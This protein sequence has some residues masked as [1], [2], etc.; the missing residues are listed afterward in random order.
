[1]P[2]TGYT[3]FQFTAGEQPTVSKWNLIPNNDAAMNSGNGINDGAILWRH[4]ATDIIPTGIVLLYPG[5]SSPS[6]QWLVCDGSAVS[7]AT[8]SALFSLIGTKYGTGNG[9]TTF[10]LPN[11]KGRVPVGVNA[12]DT[13]FAALGQ[14][15][16]ESTHAL[17]TAELAVH[18]HTISD[19]GHSHG[20]NDPG[21]IHSSNTSGQTLF[22]AGSTNT[23]TDNRSGGFQ[24]I[25]WGNTVTGGSGT[26]I[27]LSGSGTGITIANA[28]SGTAH[29]NLQPYTVINFI[30]KI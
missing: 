22:T 20:V 9:S 24:Q 4:L 15:G 16:G 11:F 19:P 8:Y 21:H 10:N 12:T 3:G 1:M 26:G 27:F 2:A 17:T 5:T 13:N 28:G 30:I 14:T 29:N 6:A 25:T 7:R 18:N 23:T